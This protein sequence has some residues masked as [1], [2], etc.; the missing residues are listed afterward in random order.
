MHTYKGIPLSRNKKATEAAINL[1]LCK[2]GR[3]ELFDFMGKHARDMK[4]KDL[5]KTMSKIKGSMSDDIIEHR[6]ERT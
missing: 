6:E 1:I 5:R 4:L 2:S 3:Y